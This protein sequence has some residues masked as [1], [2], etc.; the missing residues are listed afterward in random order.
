MDMNAIKMRV[1][2][3]IVSVTLAKTAGFLSN[4]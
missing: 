4:I 1:L 2:F 3:F